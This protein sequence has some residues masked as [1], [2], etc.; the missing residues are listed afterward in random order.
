M[1][2]NCNIPHPLIRI[3]HYYVDMSSDFVAR[4]TALTFVPFAFDGPVVS[5]LDNANLEETISSVTLALGSRDLDLGKIVRRGVILRGVASG[6]YV[7]DVMFV[8]S[9]L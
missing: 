1:V 2:I 3:C 6:I 5:L 8:L 7:L 9:I 4:C